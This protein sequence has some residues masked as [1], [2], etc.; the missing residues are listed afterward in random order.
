M[1]LWCLVFWEWKLFFEG[2]A[3]GALEKDPGPILVSV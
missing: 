3:E 1:G 2:E